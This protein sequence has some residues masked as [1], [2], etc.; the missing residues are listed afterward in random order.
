MVY[1]RDS[2]YFHLYTAYERRILKGQF[3]GLTADEAFARNTD[4]PRCP[5]SRAFR[6][7]EFSQLARAAGFDVE[8]LGGYFADVELELWRELGAEAAADERLGEEHRDFLAQ[9]SDD[10]DGFPRFDGHLAGVG[11][12]YAVR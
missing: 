12:V 10:A 4:G 6:P 1:N 2:L 9:V 5:I 8:F 3:Q 11:G 7:P